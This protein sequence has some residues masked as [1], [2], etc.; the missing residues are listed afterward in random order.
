MIWHT[1]R[2]GGK[3]EEEEEEGI[4]DDFEGRRGDTLF[5]LER[6]IKNSAWLMQC[7]RRG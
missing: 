7:H 3:R 4:S 1:K 5:V 2:K 6:G